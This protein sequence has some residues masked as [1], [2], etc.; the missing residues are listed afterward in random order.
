V[1]LR[2]TEVFVFFF[3]AQLLQWVWR[4]ERRGGGGSGV[5]F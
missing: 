4:R 2:K 3:L 1:L 5:E